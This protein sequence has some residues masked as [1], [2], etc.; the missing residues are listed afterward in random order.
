MAFS[1][2]FY[3][4]ILGKKMRNNLMWCYTNLTFMKLYF[5]LNKFLFN[6]A[7]SVIFSSCNKNPLKKTDEE[8]HEDSH[9]A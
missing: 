4:K 8:A 7:W 6:L 9:E 3:L 1:S 2:V 5:L